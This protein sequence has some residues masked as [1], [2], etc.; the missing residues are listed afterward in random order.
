MIV[1]VHNPKGGTGK[2]ITAVNVAAVLAGMGRR[3]LL[4]DLE[5]YAGAS[6]SLGVAPAD[7]RP[8]IADVLLGHIRPQQGTRGV[9]AVPNLSLL[10][11]SHAL[12]DIDPALA[13]A[14]Q[15]ERRL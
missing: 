3:V 4:I 7:L 12:I 14:R 11:G 1:G 9:A 8:S 2:T 10:T 6:I 15:P 5:P 13:D